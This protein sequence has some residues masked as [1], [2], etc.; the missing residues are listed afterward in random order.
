[1]VEAVGA[2][3]FVAASINISFGKGFESS[4]FHGGFSS[5]VRAR[6][7]PPALT[8]PFLGLFIADQTVRDA[9]RPC[10]PED[11]PRVP[12]SCPLLYPPA[13]YFCHLDLPPPPCERSGD[14]FTS[15]P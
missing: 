6:L 12:V 13:P 14:L 11:S 7:R 15:M 2:I 10:H 3:Q 8:K 5:V 1:M 4:V 9:V